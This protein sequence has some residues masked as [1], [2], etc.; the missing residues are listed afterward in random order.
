M[1]TQSVHDCSHS[2][3]QDFHWGWHFFREK[4]DKVFSSR[5]QNIEA[6]MLNQPLSKPSN[7]PYPAKISS[8]IR[9]L[10]RHFSDFILWVS[11]LIP[12]SVILQSIRNTSIA[13]TW[14]FRLWGLLR[15]HK[16]TYFL[17]YLSPT[18][19][20][21]S[22]G[23]VLNTGAESYQ[24]EIRGRNLNVPIHRTLPH[25]IMDNVGG[26]ATHSNQHPMVATC[27]LQRDT[28]W[29][30]E[31]NSAQGKTVTDILTRS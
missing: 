7:L 15:E 14:Q 31:G 18:F 30:V 11:I 19:S 29:S 21:Q 25:T 4:V 20:I 27:S 16:F 23:P 9:L 13:P 28:V 24:P 10:L 12:D 17:T 1:C 26:P 2:L 5:P 8:E 3:T 22:D 6:K